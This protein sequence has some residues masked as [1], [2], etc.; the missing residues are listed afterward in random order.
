MFSICRF[1]DPVKLRNPDRCRTNVKSVAAKLACT[2]DLSEF[3]RMTRGESGRAPSENLLH[4]TASRYCSFRGDYYSELY[5]R[6][7]MFVKE[8]RTAGLLLAGKQ[9]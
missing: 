7:G 3:Q 8:A 4:V 9:N 2:S 1:A 6:T 5:L